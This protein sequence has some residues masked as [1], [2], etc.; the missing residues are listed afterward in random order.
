MKVR[1]GELS[2][3]VVERAK[4]ALCCFMSR[5]ALYA[6]TFR[7]SCCLAQ[8][9]S[10][11]FTKQTQLSHNS[12]YEKIWGRHLLLSHG[13]RRRAKYECIKT[14]NVLCIKNICWM[15]TVRNTKVTPDNTIFLFFSLSYFIRTIWVSCPFL[16]LRTC[17]EVKSCER[18]DVLCCAQV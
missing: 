16:W 10:L 13:S 3:E 8:P 11:R 6:R 1:D 7:C 5:S 17:E 9:L 12:E 4:G 18:E 2:Y 14:S 15:L